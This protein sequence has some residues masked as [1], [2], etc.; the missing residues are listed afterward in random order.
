MATSPLVG[1]PASTWLPCKHR[2]YRRAW[3]TPMAAFPRLAPPQIYRASLWLLAPLQVPQSPPWSGHARGY[4]PPVDS[5]TNLPRGPDGCWL[6]CKHHSYHRVW[7]MPVVASPGWLPYS[8]ILMDAAPLLDPIQPIAA[9]YWARGC[10]TAFLFG[11]GSS[12]GKHGLDYMDHGLG[13]VRHTYSWSRTRG[14]GHGNGEPMT[15]EDFEPGYRGA[16]A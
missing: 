16:A 9:I 10:R 3:F 6:P 15:L 14:Q 5:P 12:G 2:R 7:S 1:S 4:I 11:P 13:C 8:P